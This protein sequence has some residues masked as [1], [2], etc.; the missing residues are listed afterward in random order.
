VKRRLAAR[1]PPRPSTVFARLLKRKRGFTWET[2]GEQ[3]LRRYKPSYFDG[4]LRSAL[5]RWA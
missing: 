3:L 5:R 4:T 2:D 1:D